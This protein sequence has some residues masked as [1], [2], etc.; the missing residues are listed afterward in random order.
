VP[1]KVPGTTLS[2]MSAMTRPDVWAMPYVSYLFTLE[3]RKLVYLG[4]RGPPGRRGG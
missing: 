3:S 1:G 2:F 4:K